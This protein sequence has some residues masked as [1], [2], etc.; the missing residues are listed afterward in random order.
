MVFEARLTPCIEVSFGE[1][2]VRTQAPVP[3]DARNAMSGRARGVCNP[4][5]AESSRLGPGSPQRGTGF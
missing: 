3:H 1:G 5:A 2:A 4:V